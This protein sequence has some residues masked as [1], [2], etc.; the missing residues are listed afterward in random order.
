MELKEFLVEGKKAC[1]AGGGPTLTPFRPGAKDL[2]Y[3]KGKLLY[4]DTYVGSNT[5]AGEEGLWVQ[6]KPLWVMNYIG[7]LLDDN[8]NYDFLIKALSMVTVEFP[9]RGPSNYSEGD[10]T[11]TCHVSGD[12]SWFSGSE[13]ITFKGK[14]YYEGSFH[15][16][17][18]I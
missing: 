6:D 2:K 14:K 17:S 15:G 11:Y 16:G 7:R 9:Y 4:F 10:A 3:E 12:F 1:Y 8:Y 18:I 13:Q 5:F